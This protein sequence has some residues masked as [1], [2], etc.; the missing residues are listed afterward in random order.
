MKNTANIL[1]SACIV[2][3]SVTLLVISI[4]MFEFLP[5]ELAIVL[6]ALSTITF[7]LAFLA[8]LFIDYNT[9]V[10]ECK[11]CGQ[12][13]KPSFWAYFFGMHTITTRHLKCPH[14]KERS[15]CKRR[16]EERL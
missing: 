10:Y 2:F 9:G 16:L 6:I 5:V 4:V 12:K 13:F 7:I 1:L 15:F 8:A 3:I 14:C 11:K